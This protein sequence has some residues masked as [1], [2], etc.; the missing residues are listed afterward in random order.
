MI[1]YRIEDDYNSGPFVSDFSSTLSNKKLKDW[2]RHTILLP[3]LRMEKPEFS[4]SDY[5]GY[6]SGVPSLELADRW[7][8]PF[9]NLLGRRGYI[10]SEYDV[11]DCFVVSGKLQLVFQRD[12]AVLVKRGKRWQFRRESAP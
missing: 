5:P 7:F 6:I 11:D 12:S 3:N 8:K 9:Y 4:Y 10:I 1:V 2:R